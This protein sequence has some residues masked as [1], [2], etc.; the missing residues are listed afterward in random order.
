MNQKRWQLLISGK[1]DSLIQNIEDNSVST[2]SVTG[3]Y[4]S[5]K[6]FAISQTI[7]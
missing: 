7:V 2:I 6:A 1:I 3:L 5:A 4:S